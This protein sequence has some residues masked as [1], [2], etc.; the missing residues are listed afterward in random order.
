MMVQR[1]RPRKR[2]SKRRSREPG[3]RVQ[4][5]DLTSL[6]KLRQSITKQ[7]QAAAPHMVEQ[8]L[9]EACNK[10]NIP[11]MKFLFEMIGFYPA[12]AEAKE[13]TGDESLAKALWNSLG[14]PDAPAAK[15]EEGAAEAG[16]AGDALE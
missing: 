9:D 12:G 6:D 10:A 4:D 8:A 13:E 11:A 15:M 5:P 16:F 3:T 2:T 7:V 14:L 1:L